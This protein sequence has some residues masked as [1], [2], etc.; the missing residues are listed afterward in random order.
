MNTTWTTA[1]ITSSGMVFSGVFTSEEMTRPNII[2]VK[3][4]ALITTQTS[5]AVGTSRQHK[6]QRHEA[7]VRGDDGDIAADQRPQLP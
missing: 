2:D 5:T 6:H 1:N 7:L 4:S 3:P